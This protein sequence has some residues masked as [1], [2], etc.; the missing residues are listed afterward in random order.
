MVAEKKFLVTLCHCYALSDSDLPGQ[1][2]PDS[3]NYNCCHGGDTKFETMKIFVKKK[4]LL[5]FF[6]DCLKKIARIERHGDAVFPVCLQVVNQ[7]LRQDFYWQMSRSRN[8]SL[9]GSL[10]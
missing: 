4:K 3:Y 6:S 9:I 2:N 10:I 7:D 5:K 1:L 8:T